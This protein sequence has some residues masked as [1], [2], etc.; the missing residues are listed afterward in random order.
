MGSSHRRGPNR[1]DLGRSGMSHGKDLAWSVA[2]VRI[3]ADWI[4][5]MDRAGPEGPG[6]ARIGVSHGKDLAWSVARVR[7][8]LARPGVACRTGGA[9]LGM[10]WS[11]AQVRIGAGRV[12]AM[13]RAGPEG[14]GV[15]SRTGEAR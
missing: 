11:V 7:T 13:D 6:G 4:V 1:K 15:T 10:T 2:Q 9:W 14:P 3:G 8:V 5:A 12:V